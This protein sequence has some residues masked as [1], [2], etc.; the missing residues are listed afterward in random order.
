[1]TQ[2]K[3]KAVEMIQ[4]M[5]DDNMLYVINILENLQAMSVNRDVKKELAMEALRNILNFE[6]R[7][8]DNFDADKELREAREERYGGLD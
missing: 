2:L 7:L 8:P 4:R 6:K 1:M 3:E 5:P